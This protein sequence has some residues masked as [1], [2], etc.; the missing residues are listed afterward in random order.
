MHTYFA[1]RMPGRYLSSNVNITVNGV[2]VPVGERYRKF[3]TE[4]YVSLFTSFLFQTLANTIDRR[5]RKVTSLGVLYDFTGNDYNTTVQPVAA[6]VKEPW[7]LSAIAEEPDV[8]VLVGHMPVSED[9]CGS[10][11]QSLHI[12]T[13]LTRLMDRA[14]CIQRRARGAPVHANHHSRWTHAHPRLQSAR[15]AK[16]VARE[17]AL[18]GDRRLAQ[19][20]L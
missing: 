10:L 7:F 1:P 20:G 13:R 18:H 8:F 3:V 15:R 14:G 19:H 9:N 5:G 16:H 2:S 6:M 4:R 11:Y 17:R 12:R